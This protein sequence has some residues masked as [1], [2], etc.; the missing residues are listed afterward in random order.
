MA[1]HTTILKRT[2]EDLYKSH[3]KHESLFVGNFQSQWAHPELQKIVEHFQTKPNAS[4]SNLPA[5]LKVE[6]RDSVYSFQ[7]FSYEFVKLF[8]EEI[9]NF[10]A[11]SDRYEIPIHRPNSMNNYGVVVNEIGLRPMIS[12]FQ[13][14]YLWPISKVLFPEEANPQFDSHHSFIVRYQADED[15]G[16]DMHTV[17]QGY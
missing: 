9:Q 1:T 4:A 8:T 12:S 5:A 13:Q 16:L 6:I 14:Q 11:A 10:Y 3:R 15:L 2:I 7:A 17:S